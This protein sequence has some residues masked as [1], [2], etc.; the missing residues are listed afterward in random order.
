MT[1]SRSFGWMV[2]ALPLFAGGCASIPFGTMLKLSS[3]DWQ[4]LAYAKPEEIRVAEMIPLD[5]TI[6]KDGIMLS[7]SLTRE[8]EQDA[9]FTA[10]ATLQLEE[11]AAAVITPLPRADEGMHW[12]VYSLDKAGIQ[13]FRKF[14]QALRTEKTNDRTVSFKLAA[15][16]SF[17]NPQKRM[18]MPISIWLKLENGDDWFALV[19]NAELEF[20]RNTDN[21]H[22]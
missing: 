9:F 13:K 22:E 19:D 18:R 1:I 4:D 17:E 3:Y 5:I 7:T 8:N 21:P 20:T 14:Q 15:N 10:D 12:F 2:F 16:A 11:N 6:K